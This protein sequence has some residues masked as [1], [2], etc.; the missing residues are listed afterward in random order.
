MTTTLTHIRTENGVPALITQRAALDEVNAG[1]LDKAVK[2]TIRQMSA[3]RGRANIEYRDGRKVDI[4]PATPEEIAELTAPAVVEKSA[5]EWRTFKGVKSGDTVLLW[6]GNRKTGPEGE[7]REVVVT[8]EYGGWRIVRPDGPNWF[9][10]G[11][12]SKHWWTAA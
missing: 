1:Q 11:A 9:I 6:K 4:R 10:G 7:P 2:R 12:A 3:A 5:P 8:F